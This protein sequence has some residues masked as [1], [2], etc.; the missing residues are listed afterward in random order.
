MKRQKFIYYKNTTE[1]K[2]LKNVM[3][4]LFKFPPSSIFFIIE[5]ENTVLET[6]EI[7]KLIV[8]ID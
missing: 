2:C 3:I 7:L 5:E 4:Y 1:L 8:I 6:F